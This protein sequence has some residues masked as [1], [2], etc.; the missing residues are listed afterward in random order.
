MKENE[1]WLSNSNIFQQYGKIYSK[2]DIS[3]KRK[4]D[5]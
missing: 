4:K 2:I 5:K 1:S 3:T